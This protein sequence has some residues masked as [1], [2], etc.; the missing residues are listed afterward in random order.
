LTGIGMGQ[1]E[2]VLYAL[3]IPILNPPGTF[4]PHAH[5]FLLQLGLDLGLL[6]ASAFLWLLFELFRALWQAYRRLGDRDPALQAA[7]VGLAAGV[8]G[9][10]TYGLTDAIAVGSRGSI[11]FW[12]MLGLGAALARLPVCAAD[13]GGSRSRLD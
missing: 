6:G 10:L 3:Y 9:F 4:I 11:I 5:N 1:F 12:I 13:R 7:A 8:A 2:P